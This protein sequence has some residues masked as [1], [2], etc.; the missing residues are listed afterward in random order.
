MSAENAN[1]ESA[2]AS[3]QGNRKTRKP[4]AMQAKARASFNAAAP[5]MSV[6][7]FFSEFTEVRRNNVDVELDLGFQDRE[8][9]TY[10]ARA[11]DHATYKLDLPEDVTLPT[12]TYAMIS[13]AIVRKL[14]LA[15]PTSQEYEVAIMKDFA[16]QDLFIPKAAIAAIDNLG[17]FEVDDFVARI[18]YQTQDIARML[19]KMCQVMDQHPRF[20]GRYTPPQWPVAPQPPRAATWAD[21]EID[22]VVTASRSSAS[23]IRDQAEIYLQRAYEHT[24]EMTDA[25]GNVYQVS[26]P[27][28]VVSKSKEAQLRNITDWF[29]KLSEHMPHVLEM[30]SA[31]ICTAWDEQWFTA[32]TWTDLGVPFPEWAPAPLDVLRTM[33][34]WRVSFQAGEFVPFAR[35]VL[36]HLISMKPVFD[37]FL[38]L[39]RQPDNKFGT[40]AQ[41]V[42]LPDSAFINKPLFGLPGNRVYS[43]IKRGTQGRSIIKVKNKGLVVAASILGLTRKVEVSDNYLA[44]VNGDPENL[45]IQY[46]RSDYRN[47]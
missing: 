17:K 3:K 40:E 25:Q 2:P 4:N 9:S 12:T 28:L 14:L 6:E 34:L 19:I 13:L 23:W 41:L 29:E 45:R 44:Q 11:K 31:G 15:T 24:W 33:G 39:A 46:H 1:N 36:N 16:N 47:V 8:A 37:E 21:V 7:K 32:Y 42:Y 38:D 43:S 26:Y 30:V 20:R 27:R 10:V 18:K 5:P 35:E 22:K